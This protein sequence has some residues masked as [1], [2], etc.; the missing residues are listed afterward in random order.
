[1][2]T[3][4]RIYKENI[5]KVPNTTA[6]K[7]L[8]FKTIKQFKISNHDHQSQKTLHREIQAPKMVKIKLNYLP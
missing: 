7:T 8:S 3:R 5:Q 6:K 4:E 1:M 2:R